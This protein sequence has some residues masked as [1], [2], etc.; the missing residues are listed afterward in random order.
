[1]YL[2]A[3]FAL[4][5]FLFSKTANVT[6]TPTTFQ[7]EKLK[8]LAENLL[9]PIRDR[10]GPIKITSGIRDWK[11]YYALK[12]KGYPASKTSDHFL[13]PE[14]K[15]INGKYYVPED[16]PNPTGKGAA[17]FYSD[18]DSSKD[19]FSWILSNFAPSHDFNQ[20]VLYHHDY[21]YSIESGYLHISNPARIFEASCM[22]PST[23]PVLVYVGEEEI[24]PKS[25][26]T[27]QEYNEIKT[28]KL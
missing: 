20:L 10:F 9:Q 24:F 14:I 4:E 12:E 27:P 25:Y 5:E 15:D 2:S 26:V 13:V 19:I 17:D 1:M 8:Y 28:F 23:R 18:K 6:I 7:I 22:V 21:C 3:N 16:V 11:I